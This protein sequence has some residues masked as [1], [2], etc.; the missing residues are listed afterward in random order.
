MVLMHIPANPSASIACDMTSATDTPD[1]RIAEY[2]RL[3]AH[4]LAGR[5]RDSLSVTLSFHDKPGVADW[6]Q[7]LA[8]REAACC[9]FVDY[10]IE[11]QDGR[12]V[13][14]ITGSDDP[15][16]Q[17]IVALWHDLPATVDAGVDALFD[18]LGGQG[19]DVD[20]DGPR[21]FTIRD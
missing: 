19:I 20:H 14:T 4:A 12:V 16:V 9:P 7:D 6:V 2:G 1:E 15:T 3:F 21:Q 17:A 5:H 8:R 11:R 18:R 10:R 13:W